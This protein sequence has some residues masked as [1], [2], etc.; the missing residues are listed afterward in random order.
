MFVRL[1]LAAMLALSTFAS[2]RSIT[3]GMSEWPPFQSELAEGYG[4]YTQKLTM[5]LEEM[6]FTE[7]N[8]EFMPWARQYAIV[9]RGVLPIG[10][11]WYHTKERAEEIYYPKNPLASADDVIF[12]K[13]SRFPDGIT[14]KSYEE[15]AKQN[16]KIVGI[17]S[18]YYIKGLQDAGADLHEVTKPD[19]AWKFLDKD[20]ADIQ[21][22]N[23]IVGKTEI[24]E[25][26]G[27]ERVN[28]FAHTA[29]IVSNKIYTIFSR[30]HSDG[31]TLRDEYDAAFERL[32]AT[33]KF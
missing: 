24:A 16:L 19:L 9:K 29:P 32:K 2:A 6:G 21:I 28:D 7:I 17:K 4:V 10:F 8:Y 1:F 26:L 20:R 25:V 15:I 30:T 31:K 27:A 12:Y 22:Q 33:G 18:F 14:A 23:D 11:A 5:V 13:K 3:V